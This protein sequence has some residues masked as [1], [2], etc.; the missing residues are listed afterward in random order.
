VINKHLE[1]LAFQVANLRA[2]RF[3]EMAGMRN[4]LVHQYI[5]VSKVCGVLQRHL[6]NFDRFARFIKAYLE[7][8]T[9]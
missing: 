6:D 4:L 2:L 9:R 1:N 3:R 8:E 5:D 7:R